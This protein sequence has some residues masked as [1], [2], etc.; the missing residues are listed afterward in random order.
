MK[1]IN[2]NDYVIVSDFDGTI[3]KEDSNYTLVTVLGNDENA[4]IEVDF[5]NGKMSNKE[6]FERHFEVMSISLAEYENFIKDNINID[7]GFDRF[8]EFVRERGITLVVVSAGFRQGIQYVLG[9]KR[10]NGVEVIANDLS[11]AP[12]ISPTFASKD[13]D[14]NKDF[15]P[16][17]NCKRECIATIRDK[18]KKKII[19]IGDG[20]T[21]R[22]A[23]ENA[24][25]IF[26][27]HTLAKQCDEQGIPYIPYDTLD[28]ITNHITQLITI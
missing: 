3:T 12:Y 13:P 4:Q 27:K 26:A 7:N 21:D 24:E 25:I 5:L 17:G 20:I 14:C 18:A 11:G 1:Q 16:C 19:F 9:E 15:G 23:V 8:L 10:L 2:I 28:D 22:C 6:A